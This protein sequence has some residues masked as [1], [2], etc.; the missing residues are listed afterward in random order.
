LD[1]IN[2]LAG[3]QDE[4]TPSAN[5]ASEIVA[6]SYAVAS[7]GRGTMTLT[8]GPVTT[9]RVFYIISNSEFK[10]IGV[11][12]GDVESTLVASQRNNGTRKIGKRLEIPRTV[13]KKAIREDFSSSAAFRIAADSQF[14]DRAAGP[15]SMDATLVSVEL[16]ARLVAQKKWN[17]AAAQRVAS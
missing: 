17:S 8:I 12:S 11:D 1:G 16:P 6:G 5:T 10:A 4:S 14:H 15:Q 13:S 7:N 9:K 3:F 2:V